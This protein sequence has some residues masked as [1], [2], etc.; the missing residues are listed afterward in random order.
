M[1]PPN[2]VPVPPR[3]PTVTRYGVTYCTICD[4]AL[5]YCCCPQRPPDDTAEAARA[6]ADLVR[7]AREAAGG[8]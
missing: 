7:R 5:A 4:L 3:P 8:R 2:F 1:R 6:Q